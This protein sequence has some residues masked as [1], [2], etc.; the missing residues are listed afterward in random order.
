MAVTDFASQVD[1]GLAEGRA[2]AES[3][4][5]DTC[6]VKTDTGTTVQN[7]STGKEETVYTVDFTSP[8]KVQ[9]Q[10]GRDTSEPDVGGRR[11][12]IDEVEIH[13]PASAPQVAQGQVI[14]IT[15]SRDSRLVG[16]QFIISAPMNKTY[17]TATRLSVKELP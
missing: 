17:A 14:E 13:L 5:T 16:R 12:A 3:L 6:D 4:M 8:C 10:R 7:E 2:L 1:L 15:T 9:Q 11:D